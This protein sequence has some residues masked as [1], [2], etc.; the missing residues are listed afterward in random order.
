MLIADNSYLIRRGLN[1]LIEQVKDFSIIGEA[2][3]AEELSKML[4]F[5]NPDVLIID[6][7]SRHFCL[8]DISIIHEHFPKV[9]ILA[10]TPPMPK[11]VVSKSIEFGITSH[12]WSDCG[13]EEII[14]SIYSTSMGEKYLCGKIVDLLMEKSVIISS[15]ISCNGVKISE[16]EIQVLQLIAQGLPSKQIADRLFISVHTVTTHRKN[17][18]SKLNINN[19]ALLVMYAIRENLIG[20]SEAIISTN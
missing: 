19:R 20:A 15:N 13:K 11:S 7:S 4:L 9:N 6:Y 3:K 8:D 16:R 12:L 14:E 5:S 18:M 10:I 17:I 2:E 1:S